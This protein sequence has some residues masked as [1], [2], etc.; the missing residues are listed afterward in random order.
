MAGR[1][2]AL[3][4]GN[5]EFPADPDVLTP[6]R[7][8]A[9]DVPLVAAALSDPSSGLFDV[10][11][12]TTL[13]DQTSA[14]V[15]ESLEEFIFGAHRDDTILLYYSGHG[16]LDLS[17]RL[18]LCTRNTRSDRLFSTAVS[19]A[20][21][22]GMLDASPVCRVVVVLD[23][24]H[25]GSFKGGDVSGALSGPGRCVLASTH[26]S[27]LS[28]DS[29]G[30][31]QASLFTYAFVDGLRS[32]PSFRS[33][34]HL[35]VDDLH[36]HVRTILNARSKQRPQLRMESGD[37]IAIARRAVLRTPPAPVP[38]PARHSRRSVGRIHVDVRTPIELV[39][40]PGGQMWITDEWTATE[41]ASE[42][43]AWRLDEVSDFCLSRF[44]VTVRQVMPYL[45]ALRSGRLSPNVMPHYSGQPIDSVLLDETVNSELVTRT[46]HGEPGFPA[47]VTRAVA[48]GYCRWL[49]ERVGR[50]LAIPTEGHWLRA[51][52]SDQQISFP[53]GDRFDP[54]LCNCGRTGEFD[55]DPVDAHPGGASPYRV[56]DMVGNAPEWVVLAGNDSDLDQVLRGEDPRRLADQSGVFHPRG[57]WPNA[58]QPFFYSCDYR[59]DG[60]APHPPYPAA[61]RVAMP[62]DP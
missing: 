8:P 20:Q 29:S 31:G 9:H 4:I 48:I 62:L 5:A 42:K 14:S 41:R 57:T 25:S 12:I 37:E 51:A 33:P 49:S 46:F 59:G 61:F 21:I 38:T 28:Y 32:A 27:D 11:D 40:V 13:L 7:G 18:H 6:L 26:A 60:A 2:R 23:C 43:A 3:L 54:T 15:L 1:Y 45:D 19:S 39:R 16:L 52:R 55:L 17:G 36:H 56:E 47:I 10:G 34:D 58:G 53:W 44:P 22:N 30:A 24:C 50:R 35:Y